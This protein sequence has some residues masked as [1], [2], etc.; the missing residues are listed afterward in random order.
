MIGAYGLEDCVDLVAQATPAQISHLFDLDLWRPPAPGLDEQFD[1][2]RFG[3][4]LEVLVEAGDAVAAAKLAG[5]PL[6]QIIACFAHHVDV[7]D[8]AAVSTYETSDGERWDY[9]GPVRDRIGAEVAGYHVAARRE[10]AWDAIVAVLTALDMHHP[11][12]FVALMRGVRS[13]SHSRREP[14]G[15]HS[16]LDNR[17]Q[18]MFDAAG[19][20]ERRR[21]QRGFASPAD[22]RAFLEMSRAVN[23]DTVAPNPLARAYARSLDTSTHDDHPPA[24][25]QEEE[26]EAIALLA[27]AGVMPLQAPRA[28]L[29]G[30]TQ[31][32]TRMQRGMQIAAGRDPVAFGERHFELAYLASVLISGCSIQSRPFT[33]KEAADAAVAIC[34]LGLEHLPDSPG[35]LVTHDLIG[36]FQVGWGVLYTDVCLYSAR[37]LARM[38]RGVG[39]ADDDLQRALSMLRIRLLREI[40]NN[41][42]WRASD[43]LEV[44]TSLD[45]PAWAA[46]TGLIAECPVLHAGLHASLDRSIRSVD[47][48]AFEFIAERN[49]LP[50]VKAFMESLPARMFA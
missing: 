28:L 29:G 15:F 11:E 21:Q 1:A 39:V 50:L 36:A 26:V 9:S 17:E 47:P 46:L 40:D 4:W 24:E 8:V 22:A 42:P 48:G 38:L 37:E 44:M 10:D 49:Q 34:N 7:Y 32:G 6:P 13:R 27:D 35:Y 16:L 3:V 33:S 19:E 25:A 30:D 18:M 23:P 43:G 12:R 5:M 20:R 31:H 41:T 14:D 2:S 45:L